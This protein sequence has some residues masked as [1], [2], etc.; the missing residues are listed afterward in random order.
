[1]NPFQKEKKQKSI[2]ITAGYPKIGSLSQQ[3]ELLDSY[4][5]D[6]IEIGIPFSD[7]L[8]D[9]PVIQK[10]SEIAIS[11]GMNLSIL[12]E[13]IDQI[14][15]KTPL[16]LM[17]YINPVLSYG[18]ENFVKSCKQRQ[19][20]SV[21]LPDMSLE[22]YERFY[23]DIF[24]SNDLRV[25]FLIT[26]DTNHSRI[27]KIA[28]HCRNSFVYL[29]SGNSTTGTGSDLQLNTEKVKE[30]K[31]ILGSTPLMIGFGIKS[32]KDISRVQQFADGAIIG[33]AY[34][35]ALEHGKEEEFLSML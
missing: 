7:P 28:R 8:A 17:G 1:M 16:V 12:F 4:G 2:F 24:E 32:K 15:T 35:K 9:G 33:S 22:I 5:I 18:M 6:F 30:I 3:I 27:W 13:Q 26:P 11:N 14:E 25:T 10:T 29:V 21:I 31:E 34:L 23:Q 20:A 19:I